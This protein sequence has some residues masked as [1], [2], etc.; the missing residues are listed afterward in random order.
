MRVV[1]VAEGGLDWDAV[2]AGTATLVLLSATKVI[3]DVAKALIAAGRD[4]ETPV[5]VTAPARPPSSAPS[6]RRSSA[7]PPT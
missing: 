2:A 5:A 4:P 7:S 6:S 3:G 1:N